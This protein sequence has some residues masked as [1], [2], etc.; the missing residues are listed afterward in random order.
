M[1]APRLIVGIG[2][3]LWDLLPQGKQLGG[4]PANFAVMAARLG[5]HSVIASRVGDDALGREASK[6]LSQLPVDSS[7]IQMDSEHASG[8]VSVSIN[9]GQPEYIIHESVTWDF[10]EFSPEWHALAGRADAVCFGSLAQR[11]EVSRQTIQT[12]LAA[13]F[14]ECVRV[15]DVNLRAPFYSE[16]ILVESL[17]LA[18]ILKMNDGEM[19]LVLSLLGLA[20][21]TGTS[22]DALLHGAH[23]LLAKFPVNL[24]CVT[25][26]KSG[27]L[28]ISRDEVDRHP[29]ISTVVAD[30]IGAGDAFTA[31]LT[32]YYLQGKPLNVINEAGNRWGAWMASQAGAMPPLPEAVRL[33]IAAE[34][35]EES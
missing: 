26:G 10:L 11:S 28:L 8:S 1:T 4:A 34:I 6:Y 20:E 23:L 14:P 9:Q 33:A 18:T 3:L 25:M 29:G 5:N 16:E 30:T 22:E 27:S 19:P 2:E 7:F 31:A 13:T 21:N 24:V 12:F 15:F 17:A 35:D 32:H